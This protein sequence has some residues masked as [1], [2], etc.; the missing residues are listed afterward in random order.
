MTD[1]SIIAKY[2]MPFN[3]ANCNLSHTAHRNRCMIW[4]ARLGHLNLKRLK[5]MR[6]SSRRPET[7]FSDAEFNDVRHDWC[8]SCDA[9]L[10]KKHPIYSKLW[11]ATAPV[12]N[13]LDQVQMDII[14]NRATPDRH[15]YKYALIL[16][17]V[18]SRLFFVYGL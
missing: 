8:P 18:A 10:A 14:Y 5:R 11:N 2:K 12:V 1:P 6:D 3:G 15:G 7:K 9:W 4:H 17:D 16:V 13:I